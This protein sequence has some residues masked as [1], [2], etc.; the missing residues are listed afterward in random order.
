MMKN[1]IKKAALFCGVLYAA[2]LGLIAGC[3]SNNKEPPS[4]ND[5]LPLTFVCTDNGR[6]TEVIPDIL[7]VYEPAH[8]VYYDATNGRTWKFHTTEGV[9]VFYVQPSGE[10]CWTRP[11]H[12]VAENW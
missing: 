12:I 8:Y 9:D 4:E 1:R 5:L 7:N 10:Q 2:S 6:V 11:S 3:S